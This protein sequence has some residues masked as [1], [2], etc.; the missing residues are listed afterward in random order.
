MS[1]SETNTLWE[2]D[3]VTNTWNTSRASMP[4]SLAWRRRLWQSL[5]VICT[6]LVGATPIT[7]DL[8]TLYDYDIAGRYLDSESE[9]AHW[10]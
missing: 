4:A 7:R 9:P 6:S 10:R 2:Y 3:P 5:T 8:N 1:G